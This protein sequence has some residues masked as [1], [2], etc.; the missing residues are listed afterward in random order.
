LIPAATPAARKPSGAQ[1]E[2]GI[3][4]S[5]GSFIRFLPGKGEL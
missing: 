5:G 2:L 4:C 3:S 1:T